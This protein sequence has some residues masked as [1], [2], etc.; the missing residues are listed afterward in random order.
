[1]CRRRDWRSGARSGPSRRQS[2]AAALRAFSAALRE[3][4]FVALYCAKVTPVPTAESAV[5][6][7]QGGA[8]AVCDSRGRPGVGWVGGGR[9][10]RV[11]RD[12]SR[13]WGA[14]SKKLIG[15]TGWLRWRRV[16]RQHDRLLVGGGLLLWGSSLC[17]SLLAALL[18]ERLWACWRGHRSSGLHRGGRACSAQQWRRT[19]GLRMQ[20]CVL[21]HAPHLPSW[22]GWVNFIEFVTPKQSFWN[23]MTSIGF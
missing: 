16:H 11:L 2:S 20:G 1:M 19:A 5:G 12:A 8:R 6:T 4:P 10:G 18:G 14:C 23:S 21:Y 15:R 13:G 3:R 22:V 9:F 17:G 7:G